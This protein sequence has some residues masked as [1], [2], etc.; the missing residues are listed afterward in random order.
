[1]EDKFNIEKISWEDFKKSERSR[2]IRIF[3]RLENL[4]W[5]KTEIV[6]IRCFPDIYKKVLREIN[7]HH[8]RKTY[9]AVSKI[10][11][12]GL[13]TFSSNS[14][15]LIEYQ[16][17]ISQMDDVEEALGLFNLLD[18]DR[19]LN[20]VAEVLGNYRTVDFIFRIDPQVY[21]MVESFA[22]KWLSNNANVFNLMFGT[23]LWKY[24]EFRELMGENVRWKIPR[25][26]RNIGKMIYN[27]TI[28][29][30]D[31]ISA[32]LEKIIKAVT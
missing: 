11:M 2:Y 10:C 1:M 14:Y 28:N 20:P 21:A 30:L 15:D 17:V 9:I 8:E 29:D 32:R 31:K 13:W 12:A 25:L 24:D 3:A 7:L 23:G 4:K 16:E 18:F 19:M 22:I 27:Q 6:H 26:Y 5:D